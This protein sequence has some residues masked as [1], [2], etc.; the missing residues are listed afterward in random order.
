ML[1]QV[2]VG[3]H[4]LLANGGIIA[5]AGTAL[6]ALAAKKHAVPLVVLVVSAHLAR[7][8]H[9]RCLLSTRRF[10][11]AW[12]T[13]AAAPCPLQHMNVCMRPLT[14]QGLHKLS[15]MF[16][17]DPAVTFND[18]KSPGNVLEYDALAETLAASRPDD[19]STS[20]F[21]CVG[22]SRA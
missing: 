8:K 15:P 17:H 22:F 11:S 13:G 6:V 20:E 10:V 4:T 16:P 1:L 21:T 2:L 3:A 5:P 19:D 18:F 12:G 14:F 9:T 7:H